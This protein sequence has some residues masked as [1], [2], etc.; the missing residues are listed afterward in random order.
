[1][2][3]CFMFIFFFFSSRRR[4]TRCG[5]DWSSDVCSSDLGRAAGGAH[6]LP[7]HPAGDPEPGAD[8]ETGL[9]PGREVAP[10]IPG[11]EPVAPWRGRRADHQEADGN[12]AGDSN[13]PG[14]ALQ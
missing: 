13:A 12:P 10:E 3:S 4:H 9:N 1:M 14:L 5:R 2:L 8:A 7:A 11:W 6:A